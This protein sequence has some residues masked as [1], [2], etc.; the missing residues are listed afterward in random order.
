MKTAKG[1]WLLPHDA[2]RR[3]PGLIALA[4]D[5]GAV[6]ELPGLFLRIE[7]DEKKGCMKVAVLN[8]T[9]R[10]LSE[11][12]LVACLPPKWTLFQGVPISWN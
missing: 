1:N 12:T 2:V 6:K 11:A 5:S 8:G 4:D 3:L 9:D 10:R 7:P